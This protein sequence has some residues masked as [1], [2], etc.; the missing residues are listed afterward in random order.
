MG[1]LKFELV[2]YGGIADEEEARVA[3]DKVGDVLKGMTLDVQEICRNLSDGDESA[4]EECRVYVVGVPTKGKSIAFPMATGDSMAEWGVLS[5]RSYAY[6]VQELRESEDYQ[7]PSVPK[8]FDP[9]IL[10]RIRGYCQEISK[11]HDGFSVVIPAVNG[12]PGIRATFDARL[13]AAVEH[14][15]VAIEMA[16]AQESKAPDERLYGYTVQGVLYELRDPLYLSPDEGKI[17]VEVDTR[18]GKQWVCELDKSIAPSNLQDLWRTEVLVTGVA[19]FKARKPKLE[20]KTFR[21]LPGVSDPVKAAEELIS[22]VGTTGREPLQA[23]MDR[24]RER[25]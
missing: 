12:A 24:I 17:T 8:G 3:A 10:R 19:T 22:L 6:G 7:S 14:K 1:S 25:D 23:F 18:D 4:P 13:K 11:D 16:Q 20:A 2:V 15:L 9:K 21:S 5:M